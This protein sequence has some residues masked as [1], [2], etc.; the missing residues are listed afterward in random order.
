[1]SPTVATDPTAGCPQ[2]LIKNSDSQAPPV[3]IELK[4]GNGASP[5]V[6]QGVLQAILMPALVGE[7]LA[8]TGERALVL[9]AANPPLHPGPTH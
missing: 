4:T 1:M 3:T 2:E 6:R 9:K 8:A 7:P 5:S